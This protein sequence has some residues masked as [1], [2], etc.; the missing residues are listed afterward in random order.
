VPYA[1]QSLRALNWRFD[2]VAVHVPSLCSPDDFDLT[3]DMV[4]TVVEVGD[5]ARR[6]D[7]AMANDG[8]IDDIECREIEIEIEQAIAA[9]VV[10]RDR[11]RSMRSENKRR[12]CS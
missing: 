2:H 5:V 6:V 12:G 4:K 3:R 1:F 7:S 10:L 8:R 11:A 9:L